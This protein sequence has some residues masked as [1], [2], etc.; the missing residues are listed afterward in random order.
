MGILFIVGVT[1]VNSIAIFMA[2]WGSRNKYAVL[3][4]MRGAAMLVS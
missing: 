2:G 1:S 3:G 4:S